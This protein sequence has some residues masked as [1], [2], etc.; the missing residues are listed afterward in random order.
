VANVRGTYA[1]LLVLDKET[2]ITV[3][4]L[5]SFSFPQGYYV[6]LGSA[7]GGLFRR[8][9]RHIRGGKKL[10]WHI[11]YLRQEAKPVEVWYLVSDE[12]LECRWYQA[13]AAMSRA[14]VLL[15]GFGS[16]GCGCRSHLV[17]FSSMPSFEAF[18]GQLGEKGPDLSR[19]SPE[20]EELT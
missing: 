4:K 13:A 12:R 19:I 11:D 5:A 8:V 17:Y 1:L 15:A 20:S 10:H 6:Y 9:G 18:R 16:S 7:Q 2:A 14:Q 3:G